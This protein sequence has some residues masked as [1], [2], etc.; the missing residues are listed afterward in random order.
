MRK[1]SPKYRDE[2][3]AEAIRALLRYEPETGHFYW[4]LNRGSKIKAGQRAGAVSSEGYCQISIY[5]RLYRAHRLVWLYVHGEWPSQTIDHIDGNRLN[6]RL[7][8][9][10]DVSLKENMSG[11]RS[12]NFRWRSATKYF[13]AYHF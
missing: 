3:T 2:L 9:L 7:D 6:N 13:P 8:N 11:Y 12:R 10:R 1:R 4:L 5:D